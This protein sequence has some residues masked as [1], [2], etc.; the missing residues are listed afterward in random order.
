M[1]AVAPPEAPA[2]TRPLPLA[3]ALM[4]GSAV[5]LGLGRFA[6]ALVLPAMQADL[7]WSFAVAG[8]L[9]T[10]NALGYLVG[11]LVTVPLAARCGERWAFTA[12]MIVTIGA[13]FGSAASGSVP[14]LLGMRLLAGAGG[15]VVFVIG[16]GLVAR[17]GRG[18]P[19]HV[20]T[21]LLGVY[22][23][24]SGAGIVVSGLTVPAV[25]AAGSWRWAWI[26]LG[27]LS[28]LALLAALPAA[29]RLPEL[30]PERGRGGGRWPVRRL[31][32]LIVAYVLFGAGYIAYMTFIVAFLRQGGAGGTE[33]TVFWTVIGALSV[34]AAFGWG[35]VL[36]RMPIGAGTAMIL[37]MVTAGAALP[38]LPGGTVTIFTSAFVFGSTFLTV[39]TAVSAAARRTLAQRHW[40]PA[41]AGL[42]VA[43]A[44]G[45]C[46]GPVLAGA[47]SDT[48]GGV[49]TGLAI[50]AALLAAAAVAA[51]AQRIRSAG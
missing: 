21:M 26:V 40:T 25:L 11:A 27:G 7:H 38:L 14:V 37:A 24:G 6:Y 20:A 29:W 15:A 5:A 39:V 13:L 48:A 4:A 42:T 50:G 47:L 35:H 51:L 22:Y 33:I 16:G 9:N 17:A 1:T 45:Q 31:T 32:A 34:A 12:G 10:A 30:R 41:I 43:F 28:V 18:R 23:A 44:L 46:I 8:A 2:V 19:T 3:L 36:G 49:R